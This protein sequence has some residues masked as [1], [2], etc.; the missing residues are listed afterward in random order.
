MS[1]STYG[2]PLCY[3]EPW[4]A[5]ASRESLQ[6]RLGSGACFGGD[7]TGSQVSELLPLLPYFTANTERQSAVTIEASHYFTVR[8]NDLCRTIEGALLLLR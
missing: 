5:R 7:L 3:A 1:V 2:A 8:S 6:F 4:S